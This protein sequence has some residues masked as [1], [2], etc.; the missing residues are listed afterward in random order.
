MKSNILQLLFQ[1]VFNPIIRIFQCA[2]EIYLQSAT[3]FFPSLFSVY[4]WIFCESIQS[5]AKFH[6][7]LFSICHQIS[8]ES[9]FS[10]PLNSARVNF[11]SAAEFV[12]SLDL[13]SCTNR[14]IVPKKVDNFWDLATITSIFLSLVKRK[15]RRNYFLYNR[16]LQNCS[17]YLNL[18]IVEIFRSLVTSSSIVFYRIHNHIL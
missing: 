1:F 7:S 13:V 18:K 6:P 14:Q 16:S 2:T 5:A 3:E 10:L 15:R 4:R 8:P 9:I 11:Q 12:A 17:L